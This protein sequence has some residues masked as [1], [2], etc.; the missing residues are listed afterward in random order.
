[1][2]HF[3]ALTIFPRA[4]RQET[5]TTLRENETNE[6]RVRLIPKS[7]FELTSLS[8]DHFDVCGSWIIQP[9][10]H[11]SLHA[12]LSL[13]FLGKQEEENGFTK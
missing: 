12:L 5:I 13:L 8:V 4:A 3:A 9:P 1:M 7:V 2:H 10:V 6:T 11:H